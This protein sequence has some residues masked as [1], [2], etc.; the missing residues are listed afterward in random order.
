M[1]VEA[2]KIAR[3]IRSHLTLG[4]L[5]EDLIVLATT[6]F[7]SKVLGFFAFA[8][9]ARKLSIGDYGAVETAV[10]MAA[11]GAVA[12]QLGTHAIGVR[13]IVQRDRPRETV[14]GSVIGAQFA[15]AVILAPALVTVYIAASGK[16]EYGALFWMFGASL[17][18]MPLKQAWFFQS[19]EKMGVAGCGQSLKMGVFLLAV[20][21]LTD[22]GRIKAVDVGVAEFVAVAAM[23]G[24]FSA[25][26]LKT[27]KPAR[28]HFD[29]RYCGQILIESAPLGGS[30]LVNTTAQYL[31]ILI[32]AALSDNQ[33]TANFGAA[34]RLYLS[35]VMFSFIYYFN[36][37]PTIA[38]LVREEKEQLRTIISASVRV[39]AWA[40]VAVALLLQ[41]MA[42]PIMSFVFGGKLASAG[43]AFA[44][45][46]WSLPLTLGS[47][48]ARWLLVASKR[49]NALFLAQC[50][51]AAVTLGVGYLLAQKS[52]AVGAAWGVVAGAAA[53]WVCS[54][55]A[56]TGLE[57]RA[58]LA[59]A[60]LPAGAAVGFAV[61]FWLWSPPSAILAG[62]MTALGLAAAMGLDRAF[63]RAL[64][65]LSAAKSRDESPMKA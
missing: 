33:A 64:R 15:I 53:L 48:N 63:W 35:L 42:T 57:V 45:L 49:Q 6:Q 55:L 7:L 32:V 41:S 11:I 47:G 60:L 52:G 10:G 36:L 29:A 61:L 5:F 22:G 43:A 8:Y 28:P 58:R 59:P 62:V 40:G 30:G 19:Q 23:V 31:P 54:Y 18:L 3:L 39:T 1:T 4:Q 21:I 27:I 65:V 24:W 46:V 44:I 2:Q 37:Y 56:T 26:S 12:I 14:L 20:L 25:L 50:V 9:L 38:R 34:Q 51:G 17:L 13:H 16:T